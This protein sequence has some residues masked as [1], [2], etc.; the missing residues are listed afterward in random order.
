[1]D[2]AAPDASPPPSKQER[3]AIRLAC[4]RFLSDGHRPHVMAER[5]RELADAAPDDPETEGYGDG[6]LIRTFE[7]EMAELLGKEAA[8][9]MPYEVPATRTTSTACFAE[10]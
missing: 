10:R 7:S 2:T 3:R 4:T 6:A 1:M 9:F 5:L 8:V